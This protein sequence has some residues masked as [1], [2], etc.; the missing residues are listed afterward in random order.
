MD[1]KKIGLFILLLGTLYMIF[2][3]LASWSATSTLRVLTL[4]EANSTVW[5]TEGILFFIWA[6]SVPLGAIITGVGVLLYVK[7]KRSFILLFGIGIFLV[8]FII[9]LLPKS[10]HYPPIFGIGGGLILASYL[11]ILW[12]WSK[13]HSKLEG[14]AKTAAKYQLVSYTFFITAMWYLC[15]ELGGRFFMAFVNDASDSPI[16]II[17]LLAL[18]WIFLFLSHSEESNV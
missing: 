15:G 8:T 11:G 9:Q 13:K 4:D 10:P 3:W 7:E 16:N 5:S 18:G 2:G 17:V 12:S 1:S 14:R 6:L